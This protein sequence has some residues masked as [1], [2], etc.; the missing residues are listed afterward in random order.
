MKCRVYRSRLLILAACSSVTMTSGCATL[1][2]AGPV[3]KSITRDG[4]RGLFTLVEVN[5]SAALPPAPVTPDYLPLPPG[6]A[7]SVEALAPGDVIS[8]IYYEVGARVFSGGGTSTGAAFDPAAKEQRI[9]PMEVDQ[10]GLIRLPYTGMIRAEGKTP[11]ELARDIESS[12]RGKSENPQVVVRLE[13]ANGSSIIIGGQIGAPGRVRLTSARERLLDVISLA[14]GN[15]GN[16]ADILVQVHR[17]GKISEAPLEGLSYA[18]IGGMLMEPGD[19]VELIRQALSYSVL[20]SANK[21]NRYDLS[22]RPLSLAEALATSGGPSEN[23]ADPAAVFVFRYEKGADS[24]ARPTVYHVNML[25]PASYFLS[26]QFFLRDKDVIY[27]AGAEANQPGKLLQIIG[28]I[29]TPI[30]IARQVTN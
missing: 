15:R 4:D 5:E 20:G 29:F 10:N 17:Q 25:K 30:V 23:L 7:V 19:R 13:A 6:A 11:I 28:Q 22:L 8:I 27:V 26:Q 3:G 18:N 1:P 12:L 9:G 21:V 2:Q 14:G 24:V 16:T